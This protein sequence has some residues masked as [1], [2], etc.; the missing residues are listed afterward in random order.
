M[1]SI[2][3]LTVAA[4]LLMLGACMHAGGPSPARLAG[5]YDLVAMDGSALPATSRHEPAYTV[6]AG[7]LELGPGDSAQLGL[8]VLRRGAAEMQGKSVKGRFR[9]RGD[10]LFLTLPNGAM[11]G[12]VHGD[13]LAM[14]ADD[15]SQAVFRRP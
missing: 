4:A 3:T 11:R 13:S 5:R 2:R 7:W 15:G 8:M 14:R 10:S 9:V 6:H 12:R 1:I